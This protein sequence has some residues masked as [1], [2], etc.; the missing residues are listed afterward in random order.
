[1]LLDYTI[2]INYGYTLFLMSTAAPYFTNM[3]T[4]STWPFSAAR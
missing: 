4:T 1:M 2:K 3:L